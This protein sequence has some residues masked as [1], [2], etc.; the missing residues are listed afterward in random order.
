MLKDAT[1]GMY[2]SDNDWFAEHLGFTID[3]ALTLQDAIFRE[4]ER[5]ASKERQSSLKLGK[6]DAYEAIK[7]GEYKKKNR[8]NLVQGASLFYYYGNADNTLSFSLDELVQ[9]SALPKDI[10]EGFLKRL[11]Q[12]F[13]YQN[14]Y[15]KDTFNDPYTAP[16]DYNT[17]YERPIIYHKDRYFVPVPAIFVEALLQTFYYDLLADTRYWK[18]NVQNKYGAWLE[19]KT[20]DYF[21]SIFP[22]SEV[23]LNPYYSKGHEL[24]DV[25]ILHENKVIIVQCKAK[26]LN[27]ISKIGRNITSLKSDLTK[28]I[29]ESFDQAIEAREY[30]LNSPSPEILINGNR[31]QLNKERLSEFFLMS[32]TLEGY[33]NLTT[34]LAN[35]NS[36]LNLF[37]DG[38]YPWALS[39]FDLGIITELLE[40]PPL[41]FIMLGAE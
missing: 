29:G 26:R 31:F 22:A 12:P 1:K 4:Y 15:F 35:I 36:A 25:L 3:E 40:T 10:C 33:Q 38:E 37:K 17:L 2:S 39:I 5:R 7:R 30:L 13:G 28:G 32:V 18:R 8:S 21:K 19:Q 34:R 16:W 6:L 41:F 14:S 24:C 23:Y 9:F 20:A 11:S 27:F